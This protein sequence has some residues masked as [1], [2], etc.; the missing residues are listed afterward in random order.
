[1]RMRLGA[2]IFVLLC[3]PGCA[4]DSKRGD[5]G[6]IPLAAGQ[7][8]QSVRNDLDA[9][10]RKGARGLVEARQ[11]GRPLSKPNSELVERYYN[12]LDQYLGARCH[13]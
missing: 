1:M 7:T 4:G 5:P 8:C 11:A 2:T 13:A 9:L 3:L 10:D 6:P 12:L